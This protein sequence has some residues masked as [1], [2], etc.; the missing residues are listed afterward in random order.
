M[1]H[2]A[3][4]R[5]RQAK[6]GTKHSLETRR[7]M[8]RSHTGHRHSAETMKLLSQKLSKI[9]KS[10][11]HKRKISESQKRRHAAIKTLKTI[12][13]NASRLPI[14]PVKDLSC[15]FHPSVDRTKWTRAEVIFLIK[16]TSFGGILGHE[17]VQNTFE[18][19]STI[20]VR[21]ETLDGCF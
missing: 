2:V 20:T 3:R 15:Y 9:P 16:I 1:S 13:S 8:S 6:I 18:R 7:K 21:I 14:R 12:E 5:M 19:L 4:E 17:Y 10:E 11:D